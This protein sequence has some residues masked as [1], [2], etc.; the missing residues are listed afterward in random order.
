MNSF[1]AEIK[2]LRHFTF[3]HNQ[4][5]KKARQANYAK[6]NSLPHDC[7]LCQ[8]DKAPALVRPQPTRND[9]QPDCTGVPGRR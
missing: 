6:V 1:I 4:F 7:T 5:H 8:P 2:V 3:I 9:N